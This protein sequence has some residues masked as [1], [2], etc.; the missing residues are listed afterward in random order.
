MEVQAFG[1]GLYGPVI[2]WTSST[3][4]PGFGA[5]ERCCSSELWHQCM[6]C[7]STLARGRW[8][9]ESLKWLRDRGRWFQGTVDNICCTCL[10]IFAVVWECAEGWKV[11]SFTNPFKPWFYCMHFFNVLHLPVIITHF[12]AKSPRFS[13]EKLTLDMPGHCPVESQGCRQGVLHC[14]CRCLWSS[15]AL[16]YSLAA[17]ERSRGHECGCLMA[18]HLEKNGSKI[19]AKRSGNE[20]CGTNYVKGCFWMSS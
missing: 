7:C 14:G 2:S 18:L 1:C 11:I 13:A 12:P 3:D 5:P 10:F 6:C 16:V 15:Q 4:H 8:N 20:T 9:V 19:H 17:A